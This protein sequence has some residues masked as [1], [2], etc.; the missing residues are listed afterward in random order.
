MIRKLIFATFLTLAP[1]LADTVNYTYDDAGRLTTVA[2][3]NGQT[4]A[5]T[6]DKAG[7]LLNRV[8]TAP[9]SA[10]AAQSNRENARKSSK[11]K[12]SKMKEQ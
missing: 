8:V 6:Y 4:I 9:V 2:Y 5:Y 7:N 12:I 10:S 3:A 1:L 11:R